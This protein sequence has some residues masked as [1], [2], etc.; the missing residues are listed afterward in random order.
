MRPHSS[1]ELPCCSSACQDVI[2]ATS[3]RDKETGLAKPPGLYG[4]Y[5]SLG[6]RSRR[7]GPGP[8]AG[9]T[10]PS[11]QPT[12]QRERGREEA[13]RRDPKSGGE[14][15]GGRRAEGGRKREGR[16]QGAGTGRCRLAV[17][18]GWEARPTQSAMCRRIVPHGSTPVCN[19]T[20]LSV[21]ANLGRPRDARRRPPTTSAGM[22][23]ERKHKATTKAGRTQVPLPS[24]LGYKR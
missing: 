2:V 9:G 7:S 10:E 4:F 24:S 17:A 19:A 8:R 13:E 12:S 15:A 11:T 16:R 18:Y 1:S 20:L 3:S 23:W 5:G 14:G 22:L 6:K 21:P